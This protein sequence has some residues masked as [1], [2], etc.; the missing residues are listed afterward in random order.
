MVNFLEWLKDTSTD[1]RCS[2]SNGYTAIKECSSDILVYLVNQDVLNRDKWKYTIE[3]GI[4]INRNVC[5]WRDILNGQYWFT[6]HY[7]VECVKK[8][9]KSDR[10]R[11][12]YKGF[13]FLP[14]LKDTNV[15][16][17][18]INIVIKIYI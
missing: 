9:E 6:S 5:S 12:L 13:E 3:T 15:K 17:E 11:K 1:T 8:F 4:K 18:G 14:K 2:L 10:N 16:V 7:R